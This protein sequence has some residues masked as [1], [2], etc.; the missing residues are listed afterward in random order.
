MTQDIIEGCDSTQHP[1]RMVKDQED[2]CMHEYVYALNTSSMAGTYLAVSWSS[3]KTL[4]PGTRVPEG[5]HNK[6]REPLPHIRARSTL[7][8]KHAQAARCLI[9]SFNGNT[10]YRIHKADS[11][12]LNNLVTK[13]SLFLL[14]SQPNPWLRFQ[15]HASHLLIGSSSLSFHL[16]LTS[17]AHDSRIGHLK[18]AQHVEL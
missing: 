7:N 3:I 12:L 4:L 2:V 9:H 10:C 15:P 14:A 8:I 1:T 13:H 17:S 6:V 18:F 5:G 11:C 16:Q